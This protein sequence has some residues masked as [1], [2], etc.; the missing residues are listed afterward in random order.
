MY[1]HKSLAK[2]INSVSFIHE[3]HT[4]YLLATLYNI[5]AHLDQRN[6][7]KMCIC[8]FFMHNYVHL[9]QYRCVLG[10]GSIKDRILEPPMYGSLKTKNLASLTTVYI[11]QFLDL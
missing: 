5:V 3:K 10:Y 8:V 2:T 11:A 9:M 6:F 7:F 4:L 1:M